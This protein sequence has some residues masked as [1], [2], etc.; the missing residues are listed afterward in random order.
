VTRLFGVDIETLEAAGVPTA[1]AS[2]IEAHLREALTIPGSGTWWDTHVH[3][4]RDA[5]GHELDVT[6]LVADLDAWGLAGAVIFPANDPGPDGQFAAANRQVTA[7]ATRQPERLI[8][9]CRLDPNGDFEASLEHWF[10]AGARGVKLHPVAQGFRPESPGCIRLVA[11]ATKRGMPVLIH[12][13]YGA[14]PL[15]GPLSALAEGVPEAR[16]ILA[17]GGRGDAR[18]LAAAFAGHAAVRFDTSLAT[19]GDLVEIPPEQ[20]LFG[21]DRPYGDHASALHLVGLASAIAGWSAEQLGAVMGRN[22]L[23]WVAP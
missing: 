14:R 12:A 2:A 3:V 18:A 19:L 13:G 23:S 17:H 22:L 10:A 7:A 8:P 4:G 6:S 11:H 9:F 20:L 21:S 15:A 5:D 16:I 1:Q